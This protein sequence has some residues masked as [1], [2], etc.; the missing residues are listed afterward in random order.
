M[1]KH[2]NRK[3]YCFHV[4]VKGM[5]H[6]PADRIRKI[7]RYYGVQVTSYVI[8]AL[9][10][11]KG[12]IDA[13]KTKEFYS[14]QSIHNAPAIS[15]WAPTAH[16][17]QLANPWIKDIYY[18]ACFGGLLKQDDDKGD[19]MIPYLDETIKGIK[20]LGNAM[21][22]EASLSSPIGDWTKLKQYAFIEEEVRDYLWACYKTNT[23][24]Q[25]GE[26]HKCK[27]LEIVK[28]AVDFMS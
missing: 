7:K 27:D 20:M 10:N 16:Q 2:N 19:H 28:D 22:I 4:Q 24:A 8:D 23:N 1:K 11:D 18:G 13:D 5:D 17:I 12:Y 21:G 14:L 3:P 15:G 6:M 9:T 26:C 25:C